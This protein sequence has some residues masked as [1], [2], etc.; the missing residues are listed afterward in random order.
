MS[1]IEGLHY[2]HGLAGVELHLP[3]FEVDKENV[4]NRIYIARMGY[5]NNDTKIEQK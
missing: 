5:H 1:V 4:K 2:D 3:A